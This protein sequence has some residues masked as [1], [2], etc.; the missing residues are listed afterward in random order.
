MD[1]PAGDEYSGAEGAEEA[2]R[3]GPAGIP[4]AERSREDGDELP[5][6][7]ARRDDLWDLLRR[8][9]SLGVIRQISDELFLESGSLDA[10]AER[11][12]SELGGRRDL[13]PAA[14]R[15]VLP[16]SRKRLLPLLNYFDGRGTTRRRDDGRDVPVAQQPLP[17]CNETAEGRY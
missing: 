2:E 1:D 10:A 7:L 8:L 11:I 12:R 5:E 15:D 9:E 17:R 16:V 13:G 6:D 4:P 14:F 3:P